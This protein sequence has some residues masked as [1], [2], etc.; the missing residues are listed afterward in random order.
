MVE[1]DRIFRVNLTAGTVESERIPD[2][3]LRQYVGG[4]GLG[5]R[6]LYEELD[7]SVE[8]LTPR[9]VLLFMVGPLTGFLPGEQRYAVMTKSPHTG[10]FLDSY[11]GGSFAARFVGSLGEHIGVLVTGRA[12]EPVVLDVADGGLSIRSATD[13]WGND[14]SETDA[15]FDGSVA[16]VGPAGENEVTYATVA[17]DGGDHHA[18]RGGAGAVMGSKRLKAIVAREEPP[19]PTGELD[20]LRER[21]EAAFADDPRGQWQATSETMETVDYANMIGGLPTRGWQDGRFEGVDDIGIEAVKD[22]AIERERPGD[23]VPGGF[24]IET[25]DGETVPRGATPIS[26]GAGLGID[27]FDAVVTLGAICDRLG[28]DVITAGNAVAWAIR[29]SE[30]DLVDRDLSFGNE[31]AARQLIAE[32]VDRRTQLGN[33]LAEGVDSAA[34]E[35]G[36]KELIPSVKGM[37]LP[38]YDPRAAEAMA[39][40]YATSDRGA[41][42]RRARPVEIEPI[43]SEQWTHDDRV[44]AV[45]EEQDIRSVLWSLIADDFLT[46]VLREDLGAEW[47]TAVGYDIEPDELR[48]TGERIWTLIRL[49]NV[50]EGFD[51]SDDTLPAVLTEPIRESSSDG[52]AIERESFETMLDRYYEYRDWN[53]SGVPSAQLLRRL[54]LDDFLEND[55]K[56]PESD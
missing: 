33:R 20:S 55:P 11:A 35:Y 13:V 40:A 5:A 52:E 15:H 3:W 39:L 31:E 48:R 49:F 32:I 1:S 8:P 53:E 38:S 42:H 9:N 14:T 21:Y 45:A 47:L 51:R 4:K 2:R 23:T 6:F 44:Q 43:A 34:D 54:N 17:S 18:G 36:G 22:A 19:E 25:D 50:R 28:V 24:R 10:A 7:A 27:D 26:L 37:E 29:A 16:C 12:S 30:R 46:D 56:V 41:C